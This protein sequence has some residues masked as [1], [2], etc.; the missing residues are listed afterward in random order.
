MQRVHSYND[1]S[2]ANRCQ[3]A[4]DEQREVQQEINLF[5]G[6]RSFLLPFMF[7]HGHGQ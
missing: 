2:T 7:F 3:R 4:T 6:R 5:G 1:E